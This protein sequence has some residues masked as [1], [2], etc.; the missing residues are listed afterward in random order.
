M[1][2]LEGLFLFKDLVPNSDPDLGESY[3]AI[4]TQ[5]A[6]GQTM[7]LFLETIVVL[8]IWNAERPL[9]WFLRCSQA[10]EQKNDEVEEMAYK[11]R[12]WE[13]K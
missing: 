12:T 1:H 3:F 13:G 7:V 5:I 11:V 4:F 6:F 10:K 2:D 8:A 9:H